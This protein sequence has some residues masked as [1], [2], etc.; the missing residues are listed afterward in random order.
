MAEALVSF[1]E[2]DPEIADRMAESL[3]RGSA[4]R[5]SVLQRPGAL[6]LYQRPL[7]ARLLG[8]VLTSDDTA[9]VQ[10]VLAVYQEYWP[11][12]PETIANLEELLTPE[13]PVKRGFDCRC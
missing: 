2:D 12:A 3:G 11:Y 13:R 10:D 5:R 8:D 4:V 9:L 6:A 1:L 7:F